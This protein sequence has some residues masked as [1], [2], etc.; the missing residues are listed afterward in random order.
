MNMINDHD[1]TW[2]RYLHRK[3]IKVWEQQMTILQGSEHGKPPDTT[4]TVFGLCFLISR[5]IS[6]CFLHKT[7]LRVTPATQPPTYDRCRY[8]KKKKKK[9]KKKFH[10]RIVI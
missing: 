2:Y 6:F 1:S 10:V 3:R 5:F 8:P 9:E 4:V 7:K